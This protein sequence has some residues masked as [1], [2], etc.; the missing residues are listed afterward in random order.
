[1][2]RHAANELIDVNARGAAIALGNFDGVHLG[3]QAVI[4]SARAASAKLIAPLGV[5][6]F[7]PHPR[8]RRGQL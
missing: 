8:G 2:Q 6:V 4:E 1:M 3:H 5:G 7:E